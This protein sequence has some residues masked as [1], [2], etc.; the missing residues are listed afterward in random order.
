AGGS[1]PEGAGY[2][3]E[4]TV[5]DRVP[6]DAEIANTEIFGPVAAISRFSTQAEVLHAANDTPFG[7]AGY[8]FT[9]NLDRALNVADQLETGLVGINQGVPSNVAAPFGGVK[10]SG[11]GREGSGEGLE[12]Y[13]EI[14]F[15]NIA[16]RDTV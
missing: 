2:F 7:L 3:F 15:Y 4:G 12:E 14:R 13:Q 5:L 1:A 10:Q 16:R 11:L 9:E 6:A 8:V